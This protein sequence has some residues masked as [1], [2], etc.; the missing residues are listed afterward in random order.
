MSVPSSKLGKAPAPLPGPA[1]GPLFAHKQSQLRLTVKQAGV[2]LRPL[3]PAPAASGTAQKPQE[4]ARQSSSGFS[5]KLQPISHTADI[6]NPRLPQSVRVEDLFKKIQK[7]WSTERMPASK[8]FSVK[9]HS[10][11]W[12]RLK[13]KSEKRSYLS[14]AKTLVEEHSSTA[15]LFS[16]NHSQAF[17]SS[18][19]VDP[20]QEVSRLDHEAN[21]WLGTDGLKKLVAVIRNREEHHHKHLLNSEFR[22][23]SKEL[24]DSIAGTLETL[25]D[26]S[27]SY[28]GDLIDKHV[29]RDSQKT[30]KMI[31]SLLFRELTTALKD[32]QQVTDK[33]F[34]V[35]P[36][37]QENSR[38][39][40]AQ[41]SSKHI[42]NEGADYK[43]IAKELQGW[44]RFAIEKYGIAVGSLESRQT[45]RTSYR[46]NTE[47]ATDSTSR[48]RR[49]SLS[50]SSRTKKSSSTPS[51]VSRRSLMDSSPN[52]SRSATKS[53][54]SGAAKPRSK[55]S[56]TRSNLPSLKRSNAWKKK[57]PTS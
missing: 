20:I 51:R 24:A 32:L 13:E 2:E 28:I 48:W 38:V 45:A 33:R 42:Q 46:Q 30:H 47:T 55:E 15:K 35:F 12:L 41:G 5:Q 39:M 44:F 21:Y 22:S 10:Q 19:P 37:S 36:S 34:E 3:R 53:N 18:S 25:V 9:K 31:Q 49:S 57:P 50:C 4:A 29:D 7:G 14:D 8:D 17:N 11:D 54:T 6:P 43:K 16:E 56:S 26:I 40:N 27:N 23:H 1:L 52:S